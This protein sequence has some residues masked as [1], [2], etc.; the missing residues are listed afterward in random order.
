M[1]GASLKAARAAKDRVQEIFSEIGDVVG[2]GLVSHEGGYA[3]K[4]NLAAPPTP[5]DD[6]PAS[7][8][9]VPIH[10]EVVGKISK[11]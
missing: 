1:K 2:V 6:I 9:R 3:V 11:R 5:G 8:G 7:V 10:V 4:V